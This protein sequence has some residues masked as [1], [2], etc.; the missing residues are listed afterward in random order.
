[1]DRRDFLQRFGMGTLGVIITPK[2]ISDFSLEEKNI[3]TDYIKSSSELQKRQFRQIFYRIVNNNPVPTKVMLFGLANDIENN[4]VP[5]GIKIY[6]AGF[7]YRQ[8]Q[9][10]IWTAPVKIHSLTI[11]SKNFNQLTHPIEFWDE[12]KTDQGTK[13]SHYNFLPVLFNTP[14]NQNINMIEAPCEFILTPSVYILSD[15]DPGEQVDFIF[16]I[17]AGKLEI[18]D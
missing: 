12:R 2:L 10:A 3:V 6:L 7:T 1:M 16:K 5:E 17:S 13:Y 8:L 11:K 18:D 9:S 4:I 14:M 15:I